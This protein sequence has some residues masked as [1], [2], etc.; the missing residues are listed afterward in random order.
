MYPM[1][2]EDILVRFNQPFRKLAYFSD[3]LNYSWFE[4]PVRKFDIKKLVF[5]L[6][7]V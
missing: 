4:Q 6:N 1:A 7:R 2:R 5:K 3:C